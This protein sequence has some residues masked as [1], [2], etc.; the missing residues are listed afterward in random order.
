MIRVA[1]KGLLGRKLRAALTAFAIVLG[2]A[3]VSGTYVLTDTIKKG[4]DTIFTVSYK[5]ADAV[6]SGKT[7]FGNSN[8]TTAPAI[9]A[10]VLIRV[11]A[12]PGVI[13]AVGGVAYDQTHLV[14]R[15]GKSITVGGAPNLGFS[16]NPR[17]QLFNPLTLVL[18]RWPAA[19]NQIAIDKGTADKHHYAVGDTI[20]VSVHGPTRPFRITGIAELG[21]VVSIGGATL[22]IFD[23]P[24]AQVLFHKQGQ[25]DEI[26]IAK[27]AAMSTPKLISEIRAILPPT[28]VVRTGSA[29][30][31]K[32]A[33]DTTAFLS[34]LQQFLLAFGFVALFVGSFVIANT[35]SITIAQRTRELATLRTIG[36]SRRQVLASVLF[37]ALAVGVLA[38]VLGLALGV[39]LAKGLNA[40]F[41]SFGIDLPKAG[42]VFQT[43]TVIVSLAVGILVTLGAS[44]RPAIRATRVPPIAAVREGSVLPVSRLARF[45]PLVAVSVCGLGVAGLLLGAFDHGIASGQRLLLIGVG[46]LLLFVGVA[47]VAPRI[48]KPVATG[49]GPIATWTVAALALVF[50]PVSLIWWGVRTGLGRLLRKDGVEFPG[51]R[52]DRIANRLAAGNALRNPARTAS[53]AA[54]LMIGLALVTLVAVLAAGLKSSFESAVKKQF[55]ADY[56]LTSQNGFTPTDISSMVALRKLPE[57]TTVAGV[58]AGRAKAFGGQ[59]DVTGVDA[60]ISRVLKLSW[61]TGSQAT[62]ES[63][64]A[65]GT[66]VSDSFAKKHHLAVGSGINVLTPYAKTLH[67]RVAGIIKVPKGGSPFGPVTVSAAAFDSIYPNPQNIFALVN[68][69]GGVTDAN[70]QALKHALT[71]FPDAKIQTEKQFEASQEKGINILLNLLFV[72]LGLSII[73][74][75]FGIVNTLV[76]TVF[77]RT[78][79][80]GMLRAVGMTRRQVKRMIRHES[81]VT[82]LIGAALGIPL[83]IVLALLIGKAIDFAAFAVPYTTLVVFVIA[84]VIAGIVAAIFPARRASR[85]NVLAALQYE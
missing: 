64:G 77:E 2:V 83:G 76:L 69:K 61:K 51:I 32:D 60:G 50:Y 55:N 24:T 75:L 20:G 33:S 22:A 31:K 47:M 74:S 16:V 38:S 6:I 26:R 7:T 5:N 17:D 58:R 12:L 71:T 68:V 13:D 15:N 53:T 18:G 8:N 79:E 67:L 54:A 39:G 65:S 48:V 4:F 11:K 80:L 21:G 37:E 62:L 10:S 46:V 49:V 57:V 25:L 52:P 85:L 28:A 42:T 14:G 29:Q 82:A 9:P 19:Q 43:R 34:F 84:A 35:L 72:L 81:V 66:V 45:G 41:V 40:L 23:L 27:T 44:L 1:I 56:A 63:L 59:F 3:M 78:R 36:A 30:A 70:T 73:I